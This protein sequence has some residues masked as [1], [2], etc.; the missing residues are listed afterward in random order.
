[1]W[2][3]IPLGNPGAE[4]ARTR[5]NLGRLMVLRW[6]EAKGLSPKVLKKLPSGTL[7]GLDGRLQ[8]LVPA[9][10]MN[11]SGLA[12]AEGVKAGLDPARFVL[13][14][15]D[16]DLPLGAGRFRLEGSHGGHNGVRS[17]QEALGDGPLPRL[18]L[19]IGP[20]ERPLADFVLGEWTESE[21]H[22]IEALDGPFGRFLELLAGTE[23]AASLPNQVN[24]EA[25]WTSLSP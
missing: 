15:D 5:H 20:F 10:Y 11:L 18:R 4:Y 16:K 8:A 7:Y 2:T 21:R 13:L 22:R 23:E 3:L 6:M 14:Y 12:C 24:A 19:G 25:F 17:V 9:T 1:M